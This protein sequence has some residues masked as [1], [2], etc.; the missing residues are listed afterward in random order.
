MLSPI[1]TRKKSL[2]E[3]IAGLDVSAFRCPV[4][5][6]KEDDAA[7]QNVPL[8]GLRHHHPAKADRARLHDPGAADGRGGHR[9]LR[10][11]DRAGR[12]AAVAVRGLVPEGQGVPGNQG[13]RRAGRPER[14]GDDQGDQQ[15]CRT[16]CHGQ[17]FV[18][19]LRKIVV[20]ELAPQLL[21]AGRKLSETPRFPWSRPTWAS[22]KCVFN[23][24]PCDNTSRDTQIE[25]PRMLLGI[26]RGGGG[27]VTMP[28]WA[29][30]EQVGR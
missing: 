7:A 16:I 23:L 30:H 24:V 8:R 11:A 22:Q 29:A 15:Q 3:E 21:Q 18:T 6:R 14:P 19:E 20:E 25:T 2:A 13:V 26:S 5:P 10:P 12:E 28:A 9:L 17:D 1:L 27:A 4:L